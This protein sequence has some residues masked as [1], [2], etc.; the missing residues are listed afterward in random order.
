MRFHISTF[1]RF[2]SFQLAEELSSL[3]HEVVLSTGYPKFWIRRKLPQSIELDTYP[4]L[5]AIS[6]LLE[7]YFPAQRKRL[8]FLFLETF[9]ILVARKNVKEVDAFIGWSGGALRSIRKYRKMG[10]LTC[11]ERG[12][13]HIVWEK[14]NVI[15]VNTRPEMIQK[16]LFEYDLAST[17]HV[18]STFAKSTFPVKLQHKI[19]LVPL[20]VDH[21]LFFPSGK[22]GTRNGKPTFCYVGKL[23]MS[24]G[25]DILMKAYRAYEKQRDGELLIVGKPGDVEVGDSN[26]HYLGTKSPSELNE[27]FGRCDVLILPSRA[28]GWGMVVTEALAAGLRVIC[29][30][31]VGASDLVKRDVLFGTVIQSNSVDALIQAMLQE[32]AGSLETKKT[33]ANVI[34]ESIG[35]ANYAREKINLIKPSH[36]QACKRQIPLSGS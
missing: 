2:H 20:G 22:S 21:S 12:S 9:D 17:I 11:C 15:G 35:W 27:V 32:T 30:D 14:E 19:G 3:G 26:A 8:E 5:G 34:K 1:G 28:D 29:S 31:S 13:A 4:I 7:L 36:A 6:K 18:P 10:V 16:E 25:L 23:A 24:K 33:R